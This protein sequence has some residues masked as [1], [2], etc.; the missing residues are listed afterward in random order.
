VIRRLAIAV[1]NEC[2][3]STIVITVLSVGDLKMLT[4]LSPSSN[5]V[6]SK[7]LIA[8]FVSAFVLVI[9]NCV[10]LFAF[11]TLESLLKEID[12]VAAATCVAALKVRRVCSRQL[13]GCLGPR[14][15]RWL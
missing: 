7:L 12:L 4:G 15:R 13:A 11:V 2:S 10:G 3:V 9:V 5:S 14:F 1:C 8:S 6:K